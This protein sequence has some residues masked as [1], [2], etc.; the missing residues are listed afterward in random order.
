MVERNAEKEVEMAA[1]CLATYCVKTVGRDSDE[2]TE[3]PPLGRDLAVSF[4]MDVDHPGSNGASAAR[5]EDW[6]GVLAVIPT[7]TQLM[8]LYTALRAASEG[9]DVEVS[10][11]ILGEY[12]A[13]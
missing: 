12:P 3:L 6:E 8:A 7:Q 13:S 5:A 10:Q 11:E 2:V 4:E 1:R 9:V